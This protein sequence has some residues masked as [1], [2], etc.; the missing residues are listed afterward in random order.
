MPHRPVTICAPKEKKIRVSERE[1]SRKRGPKGGKTKSALA[2]SEIRIAI[3]L[4]RQR[5]PRYTGACRS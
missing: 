1:K 4:L 3:L 5:L 2:Q